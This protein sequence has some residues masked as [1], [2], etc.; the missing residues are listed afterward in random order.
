M[1]ILTN[2]HGKLEIISRLKNSVNGNPRYLL[3]IDGYTCKTKP[4]SAFAYDVPN[5]GGKIVSAT[6]GLHYNAPSLYSLRG[7]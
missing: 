7:L 2:H 5:M 6:I 3:R 1:K 4:D